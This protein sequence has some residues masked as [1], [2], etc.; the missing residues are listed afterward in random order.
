MRGN[1]RRN[2]VSAGGNGTQPPPASIRFLDGDPGNPSGIPILVLLGTPTAQ[3]RI[4]LS[5]LLKAL[6]PALLKRGSRVSTLVGV[7]VTAGTAQVP[8]IM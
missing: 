8:V 4:S 2:G 5:S 6:C 7:R 1:K 3:V